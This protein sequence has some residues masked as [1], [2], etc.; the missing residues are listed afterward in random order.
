MAPLTQLHSVVSGR[1]ERL[2]ITLEEGWLLLV[3]L[4]N[5]LNTVP[6]FF[7]FR[8]VGGSCGLRLSVPIPAFHVERFPKLGRSGVI[9]GRCETLCSKASRLTKNVDA[10]ISQEDAMRIQKCF[11]MLP[12]VFNTEALAADHVLLFRPRHA[13]TARPC[14]DALN[15][16]A[17]KCS[18]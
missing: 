3:R 7:H 1:L 10:F 6:L 4:F 14:C 17:K 13:K 12:Y 11:K 2:Q 5:V 16:R 9:K 8:N 15:S 18:V